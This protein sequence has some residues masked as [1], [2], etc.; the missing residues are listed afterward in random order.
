MQNAIDYAKQDP[1]S[2]YAQELQKRIQSGAYN[3]VLQQMGKDTSQYG[4][5][6]QA[7]D[8]PVAPAPSLMD[9]IGGLVKETGE[10]YMNDVAPAAA[11]VTGQGNVAAATERLSDAD[12]EGGPLTSP[13]GRK[14]LNDVAAG[15]EDATLGTAGDAVSAIFAPIIAPIQTLIHHSNI[16][17]STSQPE[18]QKA[19]AAISS[20][21]QEHPDIAKTIGDSVNVGGA[22][23]G[24]EGLNANVGDLAASAKGAVVKGAGAVKDAASAVKDATVGT[25]AEQAATQSA[26]DTAASAKRVQNATNLLKQD[27]DTMTPT[28]K[29]TAVD[30][31]RQTQTDNKFG[32]EDV[33]YT[34]TK[35]VQRA[36]EIMSDPDQVPDPIKP[37]DKTNAVF[38]KVKSAI[39]TKGAEAEK[40]LEDNPVKVTNKEDLDMF[41]KM[42]DEASEVS[43]NAQMGAYDGQLELFRKQLQKQVASDGGGYT[44]ASYYKAL[45][46]YEDL[47]ASNLPRGKDAIIDPEGIGAA[48]VNAAANIRN[49]VRDMISNKHPDFGPQMYDLSSL[50]EAKENA[51]FNAAK[52]TSKTIFEK[53]PKITKAA[54]I[55]AEVAGVG[56]L[57][58][59]INA[60]I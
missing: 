30:E 45:K 20:W 51:L 19:Q 58:K 28:M 17:S 42:R 25:P 33:D 46:N 52:T 11:D 3:S 12:N 37:G 59:G 50:Y 26:A 16:G 21:A 6:I 56:L 24:A 13:G 38:S 44:T 2:S 43:D 4:Q 5:P 40:Y 55:G 48:K 27:P 35:E 34:P 9:K 8:A 49:A 10:N 1:S 60:V 32:G 53:H 7:P 29:K 41:S 57:A 14:Q 47:V 54:K 39:S 36:G 18:I 22:L 23:V 15:T 31:G